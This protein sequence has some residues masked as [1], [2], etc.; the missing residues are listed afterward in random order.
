M[1][2]LSP[3]PLSCD[4]HIAQED[5]VSAFVEH[6][7]RNRGTLPSTQAVYARHARDFLVALYGD[8]SADLR[9]ISARVVCDYVQSH[10]ARRRLHAT[11]MATTVL[12]SF[13]TFLQIQGCCDP[14]VHAAVPAVPHRRLADVP[15]VLSDQHVRA[16][17]ATFD[18]S[19]ASGLRDNAMT[20]CMACLGLRAGEVARVTL[21]DID[22]RAGSLR[23]VTTKARRV[24]VLPLPPDLGRSLAAYLRNGRPPTSER[25]VFV[26]HGRGRGKGGP[27]TGGTVRA[28]IRR[29]WARAGLADVPRGTHALRH[30]LASRMLRCGADLK[31]IADVL[32]H[33]HLDTTM[34]YAKV[35][36]DRLAEVAQPWPGASLS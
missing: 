11:R 23:I 35:D 31:Q 2:N 29:A 4:A 3:A 14:S 6:L 30:T 22:W 25:C 7:D 36:L 10:A 9:A 8:G 26:Q 18:L 17:M 21:E 28:A 34:I 12:R 15:K 20:L 33:R 16:L 24:H 5:L 13:L 19:R 1:N 32:R 27:L